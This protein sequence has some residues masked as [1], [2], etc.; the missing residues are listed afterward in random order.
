MTANPELILLG[1]SAYGVTADAVKARTGWAGMTAVKTGAI[2]ADRRRRR[3]AGPGRASSTAC[4]P[5]PL[6][7]H[8][9]LRAVAGSGLARAGGVGLGGAMRG[10]PTA[11]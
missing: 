4:A 8:P 2:V 1:D 5:S 7:I 6:A 11:R 9:E 3:H 10:A